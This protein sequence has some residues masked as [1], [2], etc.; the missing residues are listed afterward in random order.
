MHYILITHR[1]VIRNKDRTSL[2]STLTQMGSIPQNLKP[3]LKKMLQ[4]TML[5]EPGGSDDLTSAAAR[6]IYSRSHLESLTTTIPVK[7]KKKT[8]AT[9]TSQLISQHLSAEHLEPLFIREPMQRWNCCLCYQP[10]IR[11]VRERF[12]PG[13]SINS[14]PPLVLIALITARFLSKE[15]QTAITCSTNIGWSPPTETR[16]TWKDLIRRKEALSRSPWWLIGFWCWRHIF[17]VSVM[18]VLCFWMSV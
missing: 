14:L 2:P 5:A 7:K 16:S 1:R 6:L 15:I 11:E 8:R 9:P 12:E 4:I 10:Q 18:C 17:S 3:K 13:D